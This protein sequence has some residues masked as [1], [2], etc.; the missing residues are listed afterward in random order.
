M[1][2]LRTAIYSDTQNRYSCCTFITRTVVAVAIVAF[3]L[4]SHGLLIVLLLLMLLQFYN[5]DGFL[6]SFYI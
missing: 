1:L 5:T 6:R 2:R 4:L 3:A